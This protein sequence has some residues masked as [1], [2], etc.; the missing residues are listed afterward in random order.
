MFK[1]LKMRFAAKSVQ[2][3]KDFNAA[4]KR[5]R[6]KFSPRTQKL[7]RPFV[8]VGRGLRWVFDT[9]CAIC[10]WIWAGICDINVIGM[11][12]A[13]L[14]V[15][16]IVLFSIL[17]MNV[18]N[19]RKK[20]IIVMPRTNNTH[21]SVVA[22]TQ[23]NKISLPLRRDAK[24]G[25]LSCKVNVTQTVESRDP[26]LRPMADNKIY[27]DV[28]IE[29]RGESTIL[30]H[31]T[32]IRGNLYLQHMRKYVLPCGIKIEGNLFLR[33]LNMLEFCG[34]FTVSGNIYVSP[35]SSFGPLPRG[36][37]IGGQVIL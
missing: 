1:K 4:D 8:M 10:T 5:A 21:P 22:S 7:L 18:V 36:A 30:K 24:T 6:K 33:D 15:A 29:S 2:R 12:N 37:R 27:G 35:K 9:I 23:T 13:T 16:I 25:R 20:Q 3:T 14:L 11:L 19:C 32:Q 26:A 28:I 17:I 31:N 34:D